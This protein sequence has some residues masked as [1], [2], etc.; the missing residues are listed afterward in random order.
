MSNGRKRLLC[1]IVRREW[2]RAEADAVV[3][4]VTLALFAA[5]LALL[6]SLVV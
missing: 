6:G 3:N 1:G 4:A 5:S 2:L